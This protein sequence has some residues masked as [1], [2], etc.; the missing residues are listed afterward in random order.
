TVAWPNQSRNVKRTHPASSAMRK[1]R[2]KW[3]RPVLEVV[4]PSAFIT[5]SFQKL[6]PYE[7]PKLPGGKPKTINLPK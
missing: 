1:T 2:Q 7:S 4:H 3:L 5:S 6:A